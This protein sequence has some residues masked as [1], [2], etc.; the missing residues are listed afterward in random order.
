MIK[1]YSTIKYQIINNNQYMYN[2]NNTTYGEIV[3]GIDDTRLFVN[4][5]ACHPRF[6]KLAMIL[7]V[8]F[9]LCM[10]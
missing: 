6:I 5:A 3:L 4:T 9:G 7:T 8:N 2:I 1:Y 10:C